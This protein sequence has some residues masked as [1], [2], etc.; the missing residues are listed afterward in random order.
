MPNRDDRVFVR[1]GRRSYR[2]R[3][4]LAEFRWGVG[5]LAALAAIAAWVAWRGAH[6]D[7]ALF[8][9]GPADLAAPPA[10]VPASPDASAGAAPA[11]EPA[12]KPAALTE[13]SARETS[14]PDPAPGSAATP[15]ARGPLPA[16]LAD[17][18]WHEGPVASFDPTNLYVKIDG[19]EEYYKAFGF[20][21]LWCATLTADAA[22]GAIID[23]ELFDLG[24]AANALGA[25]AG[26]RAPASKTTAEAGGLWHLARN[27]LFMTRGRYYMRAIGADESPGTQAQLSRLR[28]I[29]AA[30]PGEPLPWAYALFLGQMGI[31][32]GRISYTAENAF[33]FGFATDVYAAKPDS[34][35]LELFVQVAPDAAAARDLAARYTAGFLDYGSAAGE[36]NGARWV[37]DRY[38]GQIAGVT[39]SG[40]WVL[41]VRNAPDAGRAGV[42]LES[43]RRAIGSLPP[44]LAAQARTAEAQR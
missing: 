32:P 41:G 18:G 27:A 3:Y 14:A 10:A 26:E 19:R 6:P 11:V 23:L 33:S 2:R 5:I 24:T 43:L 34:S 16:G 40:S 35:D 12:A 7:P 17:R 15:S 42:A 25:Y 36:S 39:P 8:G 20:R 37:R 22:P 29:F 9:A 30:L 31:D 44:G 28:T 38:L 4:S 21:Q 1:D 13:E